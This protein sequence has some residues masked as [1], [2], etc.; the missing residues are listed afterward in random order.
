MEPQVIDPKTLGKVAV[1]MG[2]RSAERD[3]SLMSG[4]GVLA[5]LLTVTQTTI[6][7]TTGISCPG[8]SM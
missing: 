3:I 4:N 7:S 6:W 8:A 1:L 2:G 5:A